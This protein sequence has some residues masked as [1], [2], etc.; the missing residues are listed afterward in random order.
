V[1]DLEVRITLENADGV[2]RAL[3]A[4]AD[5]AAADRVTRT[6]GSKAMGVF[7]RGV[8]RRMR[9]EGYPEPLVRALRTKTKV[10]KREGVYLAFGVRTK[11]TIEDRPYVPTTHALEGE[12]PHH[13][14][15]ARRV[16]AARVL[17]NEEKGVDGRGR[18]FRAEGQRSLY[19]SNEFVIPKRTARPVMTE[20]FHADRRAASRAFEAAFV[21]ALEKEARRA[22]KREDR[23]GG[24]SALRAAS[25][26]A[27]GGGAS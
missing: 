27:A 19:F 10:Y 12:D 17:N 6:A 16:L 23:A 18:S 14:E 22:F 25:R 4:L 5:G 1:N 15:G 21:P 20:S 8:R 7:R 11:E 3:E 26:L 24:R 13:Y 9:S 2:R